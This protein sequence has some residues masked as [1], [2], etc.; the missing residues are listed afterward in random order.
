MLIVFTDYDIGIILNPVVGPE[1]ITGSSRMKGGSATK[2][3]LESILLK[4]HASI[5]QP[6][7]VLNR[8]TEIL[9]MYENMY[10]RTY[11]SC[12]SIACAIE[13]AAE[14]LKSNGHVFYI[15]WGLKGFMG[16]LDASE[17]VPTFSANF[18]DVRG[19]IEEGYSTLNNREGELMLT[20]SKK[21]CISLEDFQSNF[22]PELTLHDTVVFILP[23]NKVFQEVTQLIHLIKEKGTQLIG[24]IFQKESELSNLF[25]SCIHV[26]GNHSSGCLNE[27]GSSTPILLT[28]FLNQCLQEI[29]IKWILNAISTGAHVLKGKV[30]RGLMIDVKVSNNKLFHRAISIVSTF[31]RVDQKCALHAVLK[32]IYRRDS[33]DDVLNLQISEHVARGTVMDQVVPVAVLIATD[34]F[35]IASAVEALRTSTV[36][37]ILKSLG[38][39]E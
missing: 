3:L 33:I 38:L 39:V 4:A 22:L 37:H 7:S 35:S 21:L 1:A 29:S 30:L 6:R 28:D 26:E 31:A 34:K 32:A 23:D 11:L 8:L 12:S 19:F 24:I 13:L 5:S 27:E 25:K 14:S 17:C 18:D 9:L 10:R 36:S 16:L 20:E 2:I 15:G